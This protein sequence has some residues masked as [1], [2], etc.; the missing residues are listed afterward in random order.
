VK[1]RQESRIDSLTAKVIRNEAEEEG[2]KISID[3]IY[4]MLLNP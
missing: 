3:L 1:F 2:N 4:N